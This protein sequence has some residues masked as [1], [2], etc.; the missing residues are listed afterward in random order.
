MG[1][2]DSCAVFYQSVKCADSGVSSEYRFARGSLYH[3]VTIGGGKCMADSGVAEN[4][5]DTDWKAEEIKRKT[6]SETK[7]TQ[8]HK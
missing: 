7:K 3:A 4:R 2:A 6:D 8:K 5:G 1:N